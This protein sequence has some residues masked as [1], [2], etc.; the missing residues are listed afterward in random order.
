MA[1]YTGL[2]DCLECVIHK[3]NG[4]IV[5]HKFKGRTERKNINYRCFTDY[6]W[7]KILQ[8]NNTKR[9]KLFFCRIM[10]I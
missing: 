1:K 5:K 9:G 6:I 2:I 7:R 8:R 4:K 3:P 10:P